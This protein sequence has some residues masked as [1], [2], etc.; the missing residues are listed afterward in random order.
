MEPEDGKICTEHFL[1]STLPNLRANKILSYRQ[2]IA[3]FV[4]KHAEDDK[5]VTLDEFIS[6]KYFFQE[7]D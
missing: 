5:G 3:N 7:L 1:K 2:R 6:F 4:K